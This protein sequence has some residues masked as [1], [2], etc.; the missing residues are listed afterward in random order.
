MR[1]LL[2]LVALLAVEASA[3]GQEA[4]LA[5][6]SDVT[7]RADGGIDVVESIRVRA[8]GRAIRR[9][10]F[11]D[12]PTDYRDREGRTVRVSFDVVEARRNGQT[13]PR[14]QE[15]RGNG[16]RVYL[17]SSDRLIGSGE[18]DYELRYETVGQLGF[19]DGFDELYW[20]ATGHGWQ[21]PINGAT[22]V[23]RLPVDVPESSLQL[24]CYTGRQG[25]TER[26]CRG[27]SAGPG[28]IRFVATRVLAPGEGLTVAVGFP[29]GLVAQPATRL[30][31]RQETPAW[32]IWLRRAAYFL[33]LAIV[34]GYWIVAWR[35][36]GRD[37]AAGVIVPRYESPEGLSPAALRYVRRMKY[38]T[39]CLAAAV[40]NLAVKG[41]LKI[42]EEKRFFSR[43][44]TIEQ[45]GEPTA[46][47]SEGEQE[48]L[49]KLLGSRRSFEFDNAD[50]E[51][52]QRA[53][54]AQKGA[55]EREHKTRHFRLNRDRLIYGL[56]LSVVVAVATLLIGGVP[57]V[58]E[59]LVINLVFIWLIK[60]HTSEGRRLVDAIEGLKL[61]LG[62]AERDTFAGL[63]R[64]RTLEEFER[65]LPYAVALDCA[66][67]WVDHFEDVLLDLASRGELA[68]R[69]WA[70]SVG[71]GKPTGI[72][73]S[74]SG[75][76]AGLG[77]AIASSARPPGSSSGSGGG[78]F[79]GGGGGGGGGG[80]W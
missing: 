55:L 47:L 57:P 51:R 74:V 30:T 23:V 49:T 77:G 18:H 6:E 36:V 1:R 24:A 61:Y 62:V 43:R 9:G 78:G 8:E 4:I 71:S 35:R 33:A 26:A 19:F 64:P 37:P 58:L 59:L 44:F 65:L 39:T 20:N 66:N 21:F 14:H 3:Q 40:V 28:T 11:R 80:G 46:P 52:V 25:S 5:F 2:V 63:D 48:V 10:I 17:G 34:L 75:L 13:E 70:A 72:V 15:R 16:I 27:E 31:G 54:K 32:L 29:K 67:T 53:M 41:A 73:D 45:A 38:D 60:A 79:S 50:Y 56:I 69:G 76:A 22:A 12:F 68:D 7:I 42:H